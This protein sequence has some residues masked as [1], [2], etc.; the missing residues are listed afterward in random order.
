MHSSLQ[1]FPISSPIKTLFF[2]M[3]DGTSVH[4]VTFTNLRQENTNYYFYFELH[5]N[6]IKCLTLST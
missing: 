5:N 3:S 4:A 2:N 1:S 6:D